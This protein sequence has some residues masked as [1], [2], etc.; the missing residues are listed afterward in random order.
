MK[1]INSF[2]SILLIIGLFLLSG[3][4]ISASSDELDTK[5]MIFVDDDAESSWYDETHVHTIQEGIDN[6]SNS[7]T[8]FVYMGTYFENI[9]VDKSI[10]LIGENRP[11]TIIDGQDVGCVINVT[12]SNVSISN[13]MIQNSGNFS[14]MGYS[15]AGVSVITD[16]TDKLENCSFHNNIITDCLIGIRIINGMNMTIHDNVLKDCGIGISTAGLEHFLIENNEILNNERGLYIGFESKQ[17]HIS[18]NIIRNDSQRGMG[19]YY[20][21]NN[22]IWSN[23]IK[24]NSGYGIEIKMGLVSENNSIHHNNFDNNS[25]PG[26]FDYYSNTWDYNYWSW[27]TGSD[28]NNDG[29]GDTPHLIYGSGANQDY[30]PLMNKNTNPPVF[31]WL[32][33]IS[34]I[35]QLVGKSLISILYRIASMPLLKMEPCMCM[36][37]YMLKVSL[38]TKQLS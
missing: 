21:K 36:L 33:M 22:T 3:L 12:V 24:N 29:I 37:D 34:M 1:L 38:S 19:I 14:N 7:Y 30:H 28:N 35:L 27:Y 32:M 16:Y 2:S 5:E 25:Y 17:G 20:S 9:L 10:K 23:T 15:D 8:V 26:A 13:F 4:F 31:V 6:A 18:E 11:N